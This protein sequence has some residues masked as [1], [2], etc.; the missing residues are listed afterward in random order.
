M[1]GFGGVSNDFVFIKVDMVMDACRIKF[2]FVN[3]IPNP[4][5]QG[6]ARMDQGDEYELVNM[7]F[8]F[9]DSTRTGWS[10]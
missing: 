3:L 6:H 9:W 2:E 7:A 10:R 5:K 8:K 4:F 1:G